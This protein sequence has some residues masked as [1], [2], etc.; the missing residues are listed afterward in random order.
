MKFAHPEYFLLLLLIPLLVGG[1][2][3]TMR[4]RDRQIN[5]LI[6]ERLRSILYHPRP[7][8]RQQR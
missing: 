7:R 3:L 2:V 5:L 8:R 4:R 1:A 6:A